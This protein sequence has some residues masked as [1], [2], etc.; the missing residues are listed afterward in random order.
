MLRAHLGRIAMAGGVVAMSA[1]LLA[2]PS[3]A[4]LLVPGVLA[5]LLT[6]AV[7]WGPRRHILPAALLDAGAMALWLWSMAADLATLSRLAAALVWTAPALAAL[8]VGGY[9]RLKAHQRA[10]DVERARQAQRLQW[11]RDLHDFVA[12]DISGIV[13]QAQAARF[14]AATRPEA[15]GP[16]LERIETAGLAALATMDRMVGMLHEP[17]GPAVRPLPTLSDLPGL[18]ERFRVA[19]G[20]D[21]RLVRGPHLA[22]VPRDSAAV[23]YRV[24]VEA[25]TNVRRHAAA[26]R[27]VDVCV[28][29]DAAGV[30]V[31]VRNDTAG[32]PAPRRLRPGGRGLTGLREQVHA[33]GGTLSA[34]PV[35]GGRHWEVAAAIPGAPA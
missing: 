14:V 31:R 9:P 20:P 26:A 32:P 4:G 24:V 13:A 10:A 35:D 2:G 1:S 16:A 22:S 25:L 21:A 5:A 12:H 30:E 18:V 6:A 23:A 28:T 11:A 8:V 7:R 27:R 34:G 15:A 33:A 29:G 17:D 3:S 19:G